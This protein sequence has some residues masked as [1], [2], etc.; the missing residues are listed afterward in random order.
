MK[1]SF[2]RH[3]LKTVGTNCLILICLFMPNTKFQQLNS[4]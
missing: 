1:K 4:P 3:C 2:E